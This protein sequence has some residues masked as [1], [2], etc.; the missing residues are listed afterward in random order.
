MVGYCVGLGNFWRFPYLCFTWGGALFFVP[1]LVCLFF[2]GIPVTFM[3]L[4]LGQKFQR[5]DI[6]VF[7]GI[8]PRLS[9]VGLASVFS[10]YCI[11]AYYNILIG[12]SLIYL[13]MSFMSPL[14]WSIKN[15]TDAAQ[16]TKDCPGLYISEE[17]FFK[18]IVKLYDEDCVKLDTATV[19]ADKTIFGWEV[20]LATLAVWII[21]YFITWKGVNSSSY[22]VWITVPLPCF[23]IF[24]MI[25]NGLTLENADA[26]I[27]MYLKGYDLEGN[28]PDIGEK[29]KQGKMWAQACGQIFFSLGICMG[30]MTSYS[31]FNPK[32]KPIIGDG[33]KIALTNSI[34]SFFAGFA[35]FSVVGYLIGKGSPVAEKTAS[36]GLAFIAYPA[37]IETMPAPNLWALILSIT[38]FTLGID[39]SFSMLEAASTVMQDSVMFRGWSRKLIALVLVSS[40]SVFSIVFCFNWGFT[41]F[42]VVDNYLNVYLMLLLGVLETFGAG[43]VYEAKEI[44]A[45]PKFKIPFLINA[46]GFWVAV[47][48]IPAASVFSGSSEGWIGL[49]AFWAWMLIIWIVSWKLSKATFSEWLSNVGFSGVRKLS[50]FMVNLSKLQGEN[51]REKWEPVFEYWWGFSIKYFVPFALSFLIMFS[52]DNDIT[53]KYEGYH[54]FWQIMGFLYP[55]VGLIIFFVSIFTCN[56]TMEF[57]DEMDK[58]YDPNDHEGQGEADSYNAEKKRYAEMDARGGEQELAAKAE[59][60]VS[61]SGQ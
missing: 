10:S 52:L 19:I 38:L 26:G 44:L 2:I 41:Y 23:F 60:K 13:V 6:G 24:V 22:V 20:Y 3:E 40:G 11:V 28:P 16:I 1:Y 56:Q 29:L 48:V 33:F 61:P 57:D 30:T 46:V 42:D 47:L 7:T 50:R 9:G 18:D 34:I 39:S 37:A 15:T 51:H 59:S 53:N 5:G 27:R 58:A 8:H 35:V 31:S 49:P 25:M 32:R 4:S 17:V 54:M 45:V 14:P 55:I 36:I 43:W 21:V 12:W